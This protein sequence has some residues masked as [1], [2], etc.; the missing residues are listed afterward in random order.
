MNDVVVRRCL[1]ELDLELEY[2]RIGKD[3][4][5]IIVESAKCLAQTFAGITVKGQKISEPMVQA[6]EISVEDLQEYIYTYMKNIVSDG[7]CYVVLDKKDNKVLGAFTCESYIPNQKTPLLI[8]NLEPINKII[9][10]LGE[11][12]ERLM[13]TIQNKTHKKIEKNQFVHMIMI[14]I[15]TDKLK[16]EISK[17]LIKISIDDAKQRGYKGMFLEATNIKSQILF[18]KYFGFDSVN[19][20]DNNL[21]LTNYTDTEHFKSIS[22]NQSTDCRILYKAFDLEY[23]I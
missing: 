21:I 3:D 12:D 14:G 8:G 7:F 20:S 1:E 5:E 13:D 11:L 6:V 15:K 4:E 10:V 22:S 18:S 19:D 2:K 9:H 17:D 23:N 16:K